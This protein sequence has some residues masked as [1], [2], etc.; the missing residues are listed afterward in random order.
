M[1]C[2]E[3]KVFSP[4]SAPNF[5]LKPNTLFALP[6]PKG[7]GNYWYGDFQLVWLFY[8]Q[9]IIVFILQLPRPLGRDGI[10]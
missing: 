2:T 6:R 8:F 3:H 7:H 5:W 10:K 4:A 9:S 1:D